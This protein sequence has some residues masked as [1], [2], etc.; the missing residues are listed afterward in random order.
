[1]RKLHNH[2]RRPDELIAF[3]QRDANP[4]AGQAVQGRR[5]QVRPERGNLAL[6]LGLTAWETQRRSAGPTANGVPV[7]VVL[8]TDRQAPGVKSNPTPDGC[9]PDRVTLG[10]A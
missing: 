10:G 3:A 2:K 8:R 5:R 6:P 9:T 4:I 1:M 7:P